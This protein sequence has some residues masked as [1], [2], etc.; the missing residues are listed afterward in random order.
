MAKKADVNAF[1]G[2]A[3]AL[4]RMGDTWTLLIVRD[5]FFGMKRF[6]EFEKS[7][8]I[9][10]NILAAR[11]RKLVDFDI[12]ERRRLE[13]PGQRYEYT[14]TK[15]G[16]DLWVVLTA[17]RLWSD[18]WVFGEE[19]AP[20]VA[21]DT[22]TGKRVAKVIAADADGNPVDPARLRWRLGAPRANEE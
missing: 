7:L 21:I 15:K 19:N 9:S 11:L 18:K 12:F 16:R 17:M 1:C 14:L 13:E 22:A 6:S 2:V 10:K 8:G 5:A 4:M 3:Q 20:L